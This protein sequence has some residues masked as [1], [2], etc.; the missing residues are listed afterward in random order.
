SVLG[1]QIEGW[2]TVQSLIRRDDFIS[3]IQNFD[4]T[5]MPRALREKMMRDY[6]GKPAFNY[7]TVNRASRACGPLV[8]WVIAQVRFSEILDKVEPLRQE[9]ASLE[10]Q[11]GTTKHQAQVVG[12]SSAGTVR[13]QAQ[14]RQGQVE[15]NE[16]VFWNVQL[17]TLSGD[18]GWQGRG[19]SCP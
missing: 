6:I 1:H 19:T 10:K 16:A 12:V 8:Q 13:A 4:T 7:E 9:V 18:R 17:L 5:K 15:R 14:G 11:A 2:K 3:S